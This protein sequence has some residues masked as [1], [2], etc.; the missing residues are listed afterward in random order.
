MRV[1]IRR[2]IALLGLVGLFALASTSVA[3]AQSP[4]TTTTT[5]A[6]G[7]VVSPIDEDTVLI[8]APPGTFAPNTEV[9]VVVLG[10]EI[11][12]L[13]AG[14]SGELNATVDLPCVPGGGRESLSLIGADPATGGQRILTGSVDLPVC[15]PGRAG[16]AGA[17]GGRPAGAGAL[18]R[19]GDASAAPLTAA[20]V[21]LVLIGAVAVAA[22]RR[23]RT[24][25]VV[26]S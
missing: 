6:P 7:A 2:A 21:G 19:T 8:T 24:A 26:E 4:P 18:P 3:V 10:E 9:I 11:A 12:R 20:G 25:Q 5:V 23:R 1:H 22:A 17:R 14:P 16:A 15:P 13:K